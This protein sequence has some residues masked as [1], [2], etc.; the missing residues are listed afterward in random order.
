MIQFEHRTRSPEFWLILCTICLLSVF[1][2][3][4]RASAV[5]GLAAV[6][7]VLTDFF[8]LFLQKKAYHTV[9][10]CNAASAVV[11]ALLF[12]ATIPYSIVILSTVFLVAIGI[13]AFGSRGS[14][15]FPPAAVGYLFA[16]I[17]WKQEVLLFPQ[18]GQRLAL[19]GNQ[20]QRTASLSQDIFAQGALRLDMLDF[21]MGAFPSPMGA[22]CILLLL[23]GL[24]I[25]LL[26]RKLSYWAFFGFVLSISL[27]SLIGHFPAVLL[28]SGNMLLFVLVFL[29]GDMTEQLKNSY[30]LLLAGAITGLV[31][32]FLLEYPRLEYGVVIAMLLTSPLWHLLA[33]AEKALLQRKEQRKAALAETEEQA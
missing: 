29:M 23:V 14:Y 25:L 16:L 3:G 15:L 5:L 20:V 21:F 6:T 2:Y 30:F 24:C 1:Y 32:W 18:A 19:F 11:M 7:A 31:T 13:H 22:G 17:C 4:I 8:C 27:F 10:L 9:D 12:P 26:R 33:A 28:F